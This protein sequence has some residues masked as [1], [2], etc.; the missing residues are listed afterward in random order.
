MVFLQGD[1]A[2]RPL[3]I[4]GELGHV[5]A[6][7]YLAQWDYG[8]E[9]TQAALKNGYVYD[10]TGEGTNDRVMISGDYALRR[11]QDARRSVPPP[12]SLRGFRRRGKRARPS[13][14][15]CQR[16][17]P[18]PGAATA[19]PKK[20][21]RSPVHLYGLIER[22][23]R[24]RETPQSLRHLSGVGGIEERG[25]GRPPE[26]CDSKVRAQD[27]GRVLITERAPLMG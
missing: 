22:A 4:L 1:E 12:R 21:N 16:A 26:S 9:T 24:V 5:D 2:D 15:E 25:H 11:A 17:V 27:R 20:G 13:A 18:A 8:Q 23:A 3:R 7:E 14:R 6:V 19:S 10:E